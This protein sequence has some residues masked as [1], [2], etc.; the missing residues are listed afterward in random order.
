MDPAAD[1]LF[2][3]L[4]NFGS[5]D[6]SEPVTDLPAGFDSTLISIGYKK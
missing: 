6:L 3:N 1:R 2:C 4:L 5:A